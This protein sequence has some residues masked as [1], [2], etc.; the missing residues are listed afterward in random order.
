MKGS[1]LQIIFL[2]VLA[3]S[4]NG[5]DSE[6]EGLSTTAELV[7]YSTIALSSLTLFCLFLLI[8]I[9]HTS[10]NTKFARHDMEEVN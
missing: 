4:V 8:Y 5:E 10:N 2:A 6:D 9:V 3:I 1:L 7:I